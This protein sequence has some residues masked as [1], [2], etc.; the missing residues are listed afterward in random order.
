MTSRGGRRSVIWSGVAFTAA[1]YVAYF[2]MGIGLLSA[3]TVAGISELVYFGVSVLALIIGGLNVK[4]YFWYGGGGFLMES[5]E[6]IR[7]T[8]QALIEKVT[9]PPGAALVGL[10]C[11]IFLL[12]CTSGPYFVVVGLLASGT[13]MLLALEVLVVYNLI[14]ILPMVGIT[15]SIYYG[16]T[17]T[18]RAKIWREK[19]IRQL[20][21]VTGL[22]MIGLG[23]WM[24]FFR[25]I[26]PGACPVR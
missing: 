25:P 1:V 13:S 9:S 26:A 3:V 15:L 10:F 17:T 4:D 18:A 14:F 19:R 20:H 12:P 2:L 5:P 22:V 6:V 7:S 21:L 23:I 16:L 24:I 11:A 8:I